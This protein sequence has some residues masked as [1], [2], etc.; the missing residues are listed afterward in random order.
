MKQ[1]TN[2]ED[3]FSIFQ[4]PL[5]QHA[6]HHMSAESLANLRRVSRAA[7]LLVDEH[8]GS[9]WKAAASLLVDH[10]CL[11]RTEHAYAVQAKLREQAAV[12]HNL[13]LGKQ[14]PSSHWPA[15]CS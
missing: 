15:A 2:R 14:V 9:A 7:Q 6:L 10:A 3:P 8:T 13:L 11:P 5:R 1:A 12:L 4:D